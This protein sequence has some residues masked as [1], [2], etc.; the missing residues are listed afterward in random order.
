VRVLL[1]GPAKSPVHTEEWDG[2]DGHGRLVPSGTYFYK[3]EGE[4]WASVKKMTLAR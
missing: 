2:R 3:I 1:D 4:S